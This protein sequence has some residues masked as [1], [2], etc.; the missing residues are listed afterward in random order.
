M[1]PPPRDELVV[2]LWPIPPQL[3]QT[4]ADSNGTIVKS[5]PRVTNANAYVL[6]TSRSRT[7]TPG[8]KTYARSKAR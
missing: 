2:M 3:E 5:D 7:R 1:P 8:S 4:I 6:L